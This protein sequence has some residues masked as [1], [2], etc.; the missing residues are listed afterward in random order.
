MSP[1]HTYKSDCA[2]AQ[3]ARRLAQGRRE[4]FGKLTR[5]HLA[6]RKGKFAM[7]DRAKPA[8]MAVNFYIIGGI[9]EQKISLFVAQ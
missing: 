3:N 4:K 7:L 8:N 1:V 2:I 6:T 9:G 5:A